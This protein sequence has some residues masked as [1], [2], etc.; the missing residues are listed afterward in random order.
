MADA[1]DRCAV[2]EDAV[3]R[4]SAD[5]DLADVNFQSMGVDDT[6]AKQPFSDGLSAP[7]PFGDD[8]VANRDGKSQQHR[9]RARKVD[10]DQVV[11]DHERRRRRCTGEQALD[12]T[13]ELPVAR[14]VCRLLPAHDE[15]PLERDV[16]R[17]QRTL[18]AVQSQPIRLRLDQAAKFSF[19]LGILERIFRM[20]ERII[21]AFC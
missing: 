19:N 4:K 7:V 3:L 9:E 5:D 10:R 15:L 14:Q 16:R 12:R 8:A 18:V 11:R 6:Q 21:D 1:P 17:P 13:D 20:P 2:L